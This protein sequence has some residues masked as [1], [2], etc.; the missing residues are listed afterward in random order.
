MGD[1][2]PEDGE[3]DVFPDAAGFFSDFS[4]ALAAV[5]LDAAST[6]AGPLAFS[7]TALGVL[8][9]VVV[10]ETFSLEISPPIDR[11]FAF[12]AG[13]GAGWAELSEGFWSVG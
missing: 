11:I 12:G 5:T 7:G 2:R 4:M 9:G 10:E 1:D 6:A 3:G 8:L 13:A